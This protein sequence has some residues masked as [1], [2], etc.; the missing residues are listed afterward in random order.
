MKFWAI[1]LSVKMEQDS[2]LFDSD[3]RYEYLHLKTSKDQI[4]SAFNVWSY[5]TKS[6]KLVC[7]W[8]IFWAAFSVSFV[9]SEGFLTKLILLL[10]DGHLSKCFFPFA[11]C[12]TFSIPLLAMLKDF[13]Q[14]LQKALV[15][16]LS[17]CNQVLNSCSNSHESWNLLL[18]LGIPL[19]FSKRKNNSNDAQWKTTTS[20]SVQF[21]DLDNTAL[22]KK[23]L[24]LLNKT[25]WTNGN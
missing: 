15:S 4:I 13:Q 12:V 24:S 1:L 20:K 14:T 22:N 3:E 21:L 9:A 17:L 25:V 7:F 18:Y 23:K 6:V 16:S 5:D 2:L 19:Y 8:D 11:C 10:P